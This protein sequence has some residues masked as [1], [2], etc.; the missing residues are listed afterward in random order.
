MVKRGANIEATSGMTVIVVYIE[1]IY[2]HDYKRYD[3]FKDL[4]VPIAS[5]PSCIACRNRLRSYR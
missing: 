5:R 2:E 1:G 3:H 4:A